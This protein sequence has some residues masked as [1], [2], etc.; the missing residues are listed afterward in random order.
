MP[1]AL[2]RTNPQ[3]VEKI[4]PRTAS[5]LPRWPLRRTWAR[6]TTPQIRPSGNS[7]KAPNQTAARAKPLFPSGGPGMRGAVEVTEGGLV[8]DSGTRRTVAV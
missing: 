4:I 2:M 5:P 1:N 6:A 7:P 8:I 3:T